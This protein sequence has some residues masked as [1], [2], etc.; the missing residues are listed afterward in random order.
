MRHKWHGIRHN[1]GNIS[2]KNKLD[3]EELTKYLEKYDQ[4]LQWAR[5]LDAGIPL[6][7]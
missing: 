6:E 2:Q 1:Y 4:Q 3:E 7:P 5:H